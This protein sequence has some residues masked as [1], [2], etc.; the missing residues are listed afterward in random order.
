MLLDDSGT[1]RG[2]TAKQSVHHACTPL[3]LAFSCYVVDVEGRVLLT[4]R[5]VTKRTWP[6]T[7]T[8]VCC[9]HPRL[10]ETLREAVR[11]HLR[12]ELNVAP[13]AMSL[14]LGD[15]VYRATMPDGTIE[16]EW[17]PVVV[18]TVDAAID[19]NPDEVDDFDWMSWASLVDRARD[20][21]GHPEPV[22]RAPGGA[23]GARPRHA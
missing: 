10:D 20:D 16:H 14:A 13:T 18:A 15:F 8:N 2:T 5:A 9:G 3:H 11:R 21:A 1:V 4:R 22:V 17:C 23:P 7:W 6:A 12:S 19:P